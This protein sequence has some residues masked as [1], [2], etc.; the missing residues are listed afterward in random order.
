[1]TA[2]AL[3]GALYPDPTI[4]GT[5]QSGTSNYQS[6]LLDAAAE[7]Y[8]FIFQAPKAGNLARVGFRTA[9]VTTGDTMKV[10]LQNVDPTTGDPDGVA[11]QFRTIS[12]ADGDDNVW[13]RTGLI[14]SD[15]TDGGTRRT[16]TLS[17]RLAVVIEFN[18]YVAGNLNIAV[19]GV[20][21]SRL[22]PG[23]LNYVD[24]FTAAWTK[25]TSSIAV[26]SI[27]YDDGTFS[28]IPNVLPA[29]TQVTA[30]I[31]TG[32]TPD[33]VALKFRLTQATAV[34]GFWILG[35]L[36]GDMDVVL[37]DTDGIT[38][39]ATSSLDKDIEANADTLG[40]LVGLLTP[41]VPLSADVFYRLSIKPTSATNVTYAAITV[42]AAAGA[43]QLDQM[44]GGQDFHWS[45]RTDAGAWS[46]D[47]MKRLAAGFVLAGA[48]ETAAAGGVSRAAVVNAGG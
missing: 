17:E 4:L 1:M 45:Q 6:I 37:Y 36:L 3:V 30:V 32:T 33:E 42:S 14:T 11:N 46:D 28:Y 27:E 13:K 21:S 8:A 23:G 35:A 39:L 47:T 25:Q 18:A 40:A 48:G 26:L 24:H 44:S 10:S 22:T 43:A 38:P 31:N 16:V 2:L 7:K 5:L 19:K 15:G 9:T 20:G 12:V 41:I 29:E 34:S